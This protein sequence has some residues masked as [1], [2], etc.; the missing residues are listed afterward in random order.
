[1]RLLLFTLLFSALTFSASA[2]NKPDPGTSGIDLSGEVTDADNKKPLSNVTI[3]II[4]HET[5]EKKQIVTDN[6]GGFSCSDIKAGF[7]KLI[8]QR[9]GY[10]KLVKEKVFLKEDSNLGLS[11]QM[12]EAE[13]D[14]QLIPNIFLGLV[15]GDEKE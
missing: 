14:F 9:D 11:I 5:K 10:K 12:M 6:Y 2:N 13:D 7:Y 15:G 3:S 4:S 1:M 8:F